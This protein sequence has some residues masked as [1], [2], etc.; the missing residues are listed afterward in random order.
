MAQ[1]DAPAPRT[2]TETAARPA[3][4]A[5]VVTHLPEQRR[6][7]IDV[8]HRRAGFTEYFEAGDRRVFVHTQIDQPFSGR[9]LASAL[10]RGALASTRDDGRRIAAMCPY[11]TRWLSTHHEFDDV[12]EQPRP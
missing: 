7:V 2:S 1:L 11:V 6:Y 10:V 12:V 5:P 4:D 9:G 8:G 3:A